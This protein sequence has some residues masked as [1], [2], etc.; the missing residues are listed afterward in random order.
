MQLIMEH[1]WLSPVNIS[2]D[3][4]L[5]PRSRDEDH[6]LDLAAHMNEHGY[7]EAHP[8]IVYKIKDAGYNKDLWFAATGMH[9]IEA[10]QIKDDRYPNLPLGRLYS[11]TRKGTAQD[12]M[13]CMLEDNLQHTPGFNRNLGKMPVR[14][15]LREMRKQLMLFPDVFEKGDRLLGKEWGCDGKSIGKIR[16]EIIEMLPTYLEKLSGADF[17]ATPSSITKDDIK[18]LQDIIDKGI[19]LATD[20][21]SYPRNVTNTKPEPQETIAPDLMEKYLILQE[22]L[23]RAIGTSPFGEINDNPVGK[24]NIARMLKRDGC[25]AKGFQ[26]AFLWDNRTD[27]AAEHVSHLEKAN[28]ILQE[29]V[30]NVDIFTL[31]YENDRE[32]CKVYLNELYTKL[33]KE[34]VYLNELSIKLEKEKESDTD[35]VEAQPELPAVVPPVETPA[36][37]QL[38]KEIEKDLSDTNADTPADF[39]SIAN[40]HGATNTDVL[41]V[42]EKM[43]N[44]EPEESI[45]IELERARSTAEEARLALWTARDEVFGLRDYGETDLSK[46]TGSIIFAVAACKAFGYEITGAHRCPKNYLLGNELALVTD[47]NLNG[48]R[49]WRSRFEAITIST[50][51]KADWVKALLPTELTDEVKTPN[52]LHIINNIPFKFDNVGLEQAIR[53]DITKARAESDNG[54]GS[55]VNGMKYAPI[56]ERHGVSIE[57]VAAIA[58]EPEPPPIFDVSVWYVKDGRNETY[59]VKASKLSEQTLSELWKAKI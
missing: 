30:I 2:I 51:G 42:S 27:L 45:D 10:S 17:S 37:Q 21:K 50:T 52:N 24:R 55:G 18:K 16:S 32:K 28:V 40:R 22:T 54:N 13:R 36:P 38:E 48:A 15:E 7:D 1:Q 6:I 9:R 56:A 5:N 33:M 53:D 43:N 49:L 8:I 26:Q 44:T 25:Y 29:I 46:H 31:N 11:E 35:E 3:W 19:Y 39:M 20:G 34:K 47:L 58:K 59:S 12:Y 41:R 4:E 14:S 57:L 23:N